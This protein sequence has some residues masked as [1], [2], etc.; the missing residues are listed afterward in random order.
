MGIMEKKME[1]TILRGC[2]GFTQFRVQCL[3]SM[4]LAQSGLRA[5]SRYRRGLRVKGLSKA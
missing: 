5:A 4:G 3:E 1:T 2:I